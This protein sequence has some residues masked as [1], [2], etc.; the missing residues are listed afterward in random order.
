MART[1]A[2][3][4]ALLSA[5]AGSDQRVVAGDPDA[6]ARARRRAAEVAA[7]L[8]Q[9][10]LETARGGRKGGGHACTAGT[11]HDHVVHGTEVGFYGGLHGAKL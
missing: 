9:Q 2:D 1:V 7:L 10:R 6:A 3:A 11:D 8:D 5:I 4:A